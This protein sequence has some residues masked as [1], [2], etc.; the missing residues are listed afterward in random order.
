MSEALLFVESNKA[1]FEVGK[2]YTNIFYHN[3]TVHIYECLYVGRQAVFLQNTNTGVEFIVSTDSII[4]HYKEYKE[5]KI[6][7]RHI[8]WYQHETTKEIWTESSRDPKPSY[9]HVWVKTDTI[10][11]TEE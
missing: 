4:R 11:Y 1:M 9:P 2:K 10:T 7:T 8:H 6:H 5:P 3:S